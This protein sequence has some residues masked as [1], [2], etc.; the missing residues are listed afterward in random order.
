M[1]EID[2]GNFCTMIPLVRARPLLLAIVVVALSGA[3]PSAQFGHP[4]KGTWS[5]DW[6]PT[7]EARNRL[8]L[9]L[10]WDGKAITGTINPGPNAVPL[11]KASLDPSTW[12][13]RFEAEGKGANGATIRYLIEGKIENLGSYR[14][15][16]AGTWT[17]GGQ[18]G[19]FRLTRN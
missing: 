9:E 2:A 19:D 10:H 11:Q 12:E 14:R 16:L 6:G 15:V 4:L 18:R 13:V 3:V 1:R 7:K 8:L 5:G 17:Q